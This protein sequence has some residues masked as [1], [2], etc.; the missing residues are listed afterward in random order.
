MSTEQ[1]AV[2]D[3]TGRMATELWSKDAEMT[4][5]RCL[6]HRRDGIVGEYSLL[7]TTSLF[8]PNFP[9]NSARTSA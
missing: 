4:G 9:L 5:A 7:P 8:D 3:M 6:Q 2:E 1:A